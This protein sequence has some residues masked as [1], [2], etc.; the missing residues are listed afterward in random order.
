MSIRF[1]TKTFHAYLDYPVA[2]SLIATPFLLQLGQVNPLARWLSVVVGVAA[3]FLTVLTNHKTGLLRIL[4]YWFHLLVDRF[5]GV[6][7]LATPLCSASA[8]WTRGITGRTEPQC[9]SSPWF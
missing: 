1:V 7:F 8:A 6:T 3:L 4:P 2:F 9:C 5:V